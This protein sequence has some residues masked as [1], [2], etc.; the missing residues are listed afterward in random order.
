MDTVELNKQSDATL[1]P[2]GMDLLMVHDEMMKPVYVSHGIRLIMPNWINEPVSTSTFGRDYYEDFLSV[3]K[4]G[5][6]RFGEVV[7]AFDQYQP[8]FQYDI[9]R[10]DDQ[11]SFQQYMVTRLHRIDDLEDFEKEKD[12][13]HDRFFKIFKN[14]SCPMSIINSESLHC[15][16]TNQSW[17]SMFGE[18]TLAFSFPSSSLVS[19]LLE[20]NPEEGFDP[21]ERLMPINANTDSNMVVT[22]VLS[23]DVIYIQQKKYLLLTYH[24]ATNTSCSYDPSRVEQL[25]LIG[26]LAA[27]IGHEIRNP[28]TVVKG[29]L[30][31]MQ[32]KN[33]VMEDVDYYD[34]MISELDRTAS[35]LTDYVSLAKPTPA[36]VKTCRLDE[37]ATRLLPLLWA[38]CQHKEIIF[39]HDIHVIPEI[40]A[41]EGEIR[42]IILNLCR[43]ACD[44][45][46]GG[47]ILLFRVYSDGDHAGIE[48][49]DQGKGIPD[50]VISQ[51][52]LPFITTKDS[53]TGLGLFLSYTLVKRNHG[54][55]HFVTGEHGTTFRITFPYA[56]GFDDIPEGVKH[57][58]PP[59]TQRI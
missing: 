59:N 40:T 51:I 10:Y 22:G 21:E 23:K 25:H 49:C 31:L 48:I 46:D 57:V 35:M 29:L 6:R 42:Q 47:K 37:I 14:S 13:I 39:H 15:E 18:H 12:T 17:A 26:Q 24:D 1:I 52:G 20:S 43:N 41:N 2:R 28:L 5:D 8:S 53:G 30:Q 16:Y 27:G 4:Y 58:E 50:D 54:K 19:W 56:L 32:S 33:V 44:A 11:V 7:Y 55:I 38:D 34:I 9:H 3:L 45:M 36:I